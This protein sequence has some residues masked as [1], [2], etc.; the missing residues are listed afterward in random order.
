MESVGRG[1]RLELWMHAPRWPPPPHIAYTYTHH[2]ILQSIDR[3]THRVAQPLSTAANVAACACSVCPRRWGPA[4]L[5]LGVYMWM[6]CER[7][8]SCDL[9]MA[10]ACTTR[11][12]NGRKGRPHT[13][14]TDR[15]QHTAIHPMALQSTQGMVGS[16][17]QTRRGPSDGARI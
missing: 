2:P 17:D 10:L 15:H 14:T 6:R 8:Q 12:D 3:P 16:I 7:R 11:S 9:A 13:S 5:L 4:L 1:R